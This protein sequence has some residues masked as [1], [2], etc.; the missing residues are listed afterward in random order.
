MVADSQE[1]VV[2]A[3]WPIAISLIGTIICWG[4]L[5]VDWGNG[6]PLLT[7]F[8]QHSAGSILMLTVGPVVLAIY[9][10]TI[11]LNRGTIV[12]QR[13]GRWQ[14]SQYPLSAVAKVEGKRMSMHFSQL[15]V[16]F[17]DGSQVTFDS[18]YS[19]FSELSHFFRD[20]L[21]ESV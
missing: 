20:S 8:N 1:I 16:S 6:L 14:T 17:N 13:F 18:Y 3:R 19:G 15:T 7:G 10:R 21:P 2:V 5:L 9:S 12:T 4:W 11:K